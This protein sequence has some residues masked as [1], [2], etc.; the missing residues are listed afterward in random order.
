MVSALVSKLHQHHQLSLVAM[1][2]TVLS[3]RLLLSIP[4]LLR[5]CFPIDLDAKYL[6][7]RRS[8]PKLLQ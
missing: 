1:E 5:H 4:A 7:E 8:L 3:R 6:Y 2:A